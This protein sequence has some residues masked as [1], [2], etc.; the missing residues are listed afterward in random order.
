MGLNE[1]RWTKVIQ[2]VNHMI[3][4]LIW[5]NWNWFLW[6][7]TIKDGRFLFIEDFHCNWTSFLNALNS[8]VSPSWPTPQGQI[9]DNRRHMVLVDSKLPKLR[10]DMTFL[11]ILFILIS[12]S[13]NSTMEDNN[14]IGRGVPGIFNLFT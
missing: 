12:S 10:L 8:S 2:F 9:L 7:Y 1:L 6:T 13:V 14:L 4:L 5:N 3:I 11:A